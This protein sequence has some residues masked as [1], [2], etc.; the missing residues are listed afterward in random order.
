MLIV[1]WPWRTQ[2]WSFHTDW[3]FVFGLYDVSNCCKLHVNW[4][5]T[6]VLFQFPNLCIALYNGNLK[7]C[8]VTLTHSK[9]FFYTD[10]VVLLWASAGSVFAVNAFQLDRYDSVIKM[11]ELCTIEL[12]NGNFKF[13]GVT[14][15]YLEMIFLNILWGLLL[16]HV[17]S[18]IV[19]NFMS[20]GSW[21]Q[22]Q[23]NFRNCAQ[24]DYI[25]NI[26]LFYDMTLT[27]LEMI[28]LN[29]LCF[30]FGLRKVSDRHK[31]HVN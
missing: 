5:V 30:N 31:F 11:Y 15:P 20:F 2:K 19:I 14:L 7:Y 8:G 23:F 9:W 12:C 17:S 1:A 21:Q 6:T 13:G 28:F 29:S 24:L 22:C 18:V 27:Y 26:F 16:A 4:I 25:M 10:S 3:G